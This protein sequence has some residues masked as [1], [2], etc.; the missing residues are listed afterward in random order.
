MVLDRRLLIIAS[1]TAIVVLMFGFGLGRV[2]AGTGES[3]ALPQTTD[4]IPGQVTTTGS[5]NDA[6]EDA[7][8]TTSDSTID[9]D[10]SAVLDST[11]AVDLGDAKVYGNEAERERFIADIANAGI[12]GGTVDGL[13]A[14]ADHV[15]YSLESLESQGRDPAFAVRV[16]WNESLADIRSEDLAAFAYVFN[17]APQY[18]CPF[19]APYGESVAYWLGY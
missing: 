2:T 17:T 4:T 13:L 5:G 19:S 3:S 9:G 7:S 8:A 11:T 16:V 15:C 6:Q 1:V 14:T 12:I 18:L 10:P